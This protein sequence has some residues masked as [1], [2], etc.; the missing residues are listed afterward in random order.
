MTTG[1]DEAREAE[2]VI[3]EGD[4]RK[5]DNTWGHS[6]WVDNSWIR[7][8]CPFKNNL[9]AEII[10]L[11]PLIPVDPN[12]ANNSNEMHYTTWFERNRVDDVLCWEMPNGKNEG[13]EEPI[14]SI[15]LTDAQ[16][17]QLEKL[18]TE[19]H[20]VKHYLFR[21]IDRSVFEQILDRSTSKIV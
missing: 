10:E 6:K 9:L 13:G 19:D 14:V 17:E 11:S 15:V 4:G 18:R 3:N 21:A 2:V 16:L 7:S 20:K 1:A 12:L 5:G 8:I